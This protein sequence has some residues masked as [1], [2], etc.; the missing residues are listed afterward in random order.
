MTTKNFDVKRVYEEWGCLGKAT[1]GYLRP[2]SGP[3]AWIGRRVDNAAVP[4]VT[5]CYHAATKARTVPSASAQSEF[6]S[7]AEH[8]LS[9]TRY[10]SS[11]QQMVIHPA[12][13]RII[14][15]G[16]AAIPLILHRLQ[17]APEQ[18]FWA[19]Q[20][21]TGENPAREQDSGRMNR[22]RTAWLEWGK[23]RGY[24]W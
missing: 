3:C 14:G 18:W 9:D 12:Y 15:M 7:L 11:I 16:I 13:Q 10:L 8:W 4:K 2:T 23:Q 5:R 1:A 17:K 22:L 24:S 19:L 21:I 20:S 6:N